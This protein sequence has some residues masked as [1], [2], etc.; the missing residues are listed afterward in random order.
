MQEAEGDG[1]GEMPADEGG[2][3]AGMEAGGVLLDAMDF[4]PS[5]EMAL[6]AAT[7]VPDTFSARLHAQIVR[8]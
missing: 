4:A 6:K 2:G 5:S 3:E 1:K 7:T 8:W